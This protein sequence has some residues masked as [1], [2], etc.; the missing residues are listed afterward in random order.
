MLS[1]VPLWIISAWI[2]FFDFWDGTVEVNH[3]SHWHSEV[4]SVSCPMFIR[5]FPLYGYLM[6]IHT[7]LCIFYRPL[8]IIPRRVKWFEFSVGTM[9]VKHQTHRLPFIKNFHFLGQGK[10]RSTIHGPHRKE[11]R[12]NVCCKIASK[13]YYDRPLV[14]YDRFFLR[15]VG[16]NK[17]WRAR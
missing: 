7:Y 12:H 14:K 9:E 2:K 3:Q 17:K 8:W 16:R 15:Y 1:P 10:L 5:S 6:T 4:R 13:V 11:K